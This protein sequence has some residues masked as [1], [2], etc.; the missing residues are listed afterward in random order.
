M[1]K[2]VRTRKKK[3]HCLKELIKLKIHIFLNF[4]RESLL[5]INFKKRVIFFQKKKKKL[6]LFH[7]KKLRGFFEKYV[8]KILTD[9]D[10]EKKITK[11][12]ATLI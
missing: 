10:F 6:N 12:Q 5:I 3:T 2:E 11:F 9:L 8:F 1:T 4:E 7:R